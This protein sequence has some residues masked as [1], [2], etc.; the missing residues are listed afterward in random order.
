MFLDGAYQP[1]IVGVCCKRTSLEFAGA[2]S[3][4]K[5][6]IFTAASLLPGVV[7]SH[8]S[9]PMIL[10][11]YSLA[12][13]DVYC[14]RHCRCRRWEQSQQQEHRH[15]CFVLLSRP[16]GDIAGPQSW[17]SRLPATPFIKAHSHL[18]SDSSATPP[19]FKF[20]QPDSGL[21]VNFPALRHNQCLPSAWGSVWCDPRVILW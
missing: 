11:T 4:R 19:A 17:L 12:G 18:T 20:S 15:C 9:H 13:V 3:R 5:F 7:F 10:F 6:E 1:D 21:P 14:H 8:Q 16:A 2:Q